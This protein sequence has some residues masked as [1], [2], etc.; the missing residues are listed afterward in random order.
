MKL[1]QAVAELATAHF[2]HYVARELL[3]FGEQPPGFTILIEYTPDRTV[4]FGERVQKFSQALARAPACKL[5][6][7][8]GYLVTSDVYSLVLTMKQRSGG[9]AT[10]PRNSNRLTL[11]GA[12]F[13]E[14]IEQV[15]R[16]VETWFKSKDAVYV[17]LHDDETCATVEIDSSD[18]DGPILVRAWGHSED[19]DSTMEYE[20]TLD[21]QCVVEE[22]RL[23]P[24]AYCYTC[25]QA[26][27][28][29]RQDGRW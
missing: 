12:T 19:H 23:K 22:A 11:K 4:Q 13:M 15:Q 18:P 24:G 5:Q 27:E 7:A 20:L 6:V 2:K 9:S 8:Y 16:A 25:K 3:Q 29:Y 17:L 14:Q 21:A 10:S 26:E 28:E 1:P